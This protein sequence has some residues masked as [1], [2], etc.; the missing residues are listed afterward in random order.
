VPTSA[1]N[2]EKQEDTS[3]LPIADC[4]LQI[5]EETGETGQRQEGRLPIGNLQSAIGN[6]DGAP[7]A[8]LFKR[9]G[10]RRWQQEREQLRA[11]AARPLA[12]EEEGPEARQELPLAVIVAGAAILAPRPHSFR[13]RSSEDDKGTR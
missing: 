9:V 6:G 12:A 11:L 4:R 13:R 7:L 10:E 5:G 1:P 2:L 8:R 3:P